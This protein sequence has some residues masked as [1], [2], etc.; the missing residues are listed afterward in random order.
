MLVRCCEVRSHLRLVFR[1]SFGAMARLNPSFM[2]CKRRGLLNSN[3]AR[4]VTARYSTSKVC[5]GSFA[6]SADLNTSDEEPR[7]TETVNQLSETVNP[8]EAVIHRDSS[9]R[10]S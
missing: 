8:L 7:L 6:R 1:V 5:T 9:V 4:V 3:S 10:E 2:G